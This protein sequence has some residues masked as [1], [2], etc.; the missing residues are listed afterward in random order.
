LTLSRST[1]FAGSNFT[2]MSTRLRAITGANS[3]NTRGRILLT[4]AAF[5][6]T[7]EFSNAAKCSP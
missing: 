2:R 5:D 1:S 3:S 4:P 6:P 7:S